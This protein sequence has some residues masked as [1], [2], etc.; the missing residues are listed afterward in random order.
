[1]Q[2]VCAF[3]NSVQRIDTTHRRFLHRLSIDRLSTHR[4]TVLA[5]CA[6]VWVDKMV[7]CR[8]N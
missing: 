3:V 6:L 5:R 1:M 8:T 2:I 4:I 7:Q